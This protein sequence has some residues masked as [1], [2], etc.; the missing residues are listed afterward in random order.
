MNLKKRRTLTWVLVAL[1]IVIIG[2]GT[3]LLFN[4]PTEFAANGGFPYGFGRHH[5]LFNQGGETVI[6]GGPNMGAAGPYQFMARGHGFGFGG[7]GFLL[8]V[9]LSGL[10]IWGLVRRRGHRSD[11]EYQGSE[12]AEDIL[13]RNF[14]EGK[15]DE[16]EYRARLATLKE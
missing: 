8:I 5:Q 10:L 6:P 15:I 3:V 16:T 11:T 4:V 14:A 9:G 12:S 13:R 7:L 1:G 2:L